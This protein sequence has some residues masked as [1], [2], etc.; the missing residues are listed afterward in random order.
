MKHD[1]HVD[2][3]GRH[4]AKIILRDTAQTLTDTTTK[5]ILQD[6]A[7]TLTKAATKPNRLV[8]HLT[9]NKGGHF[10]YRGTKSD[11]LTKSINGGDRFRGSQEMPTS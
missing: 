11:R 10:I 9:I 3:I 5:I 7:Q 1:E 6:T 4:T 8:K 2:W